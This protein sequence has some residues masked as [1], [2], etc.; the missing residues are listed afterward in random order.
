MPFSDLMTGA[1]LTPSFQ[2]MIR[3]LPL[4]LKEDITTFSTI[5]QLWVREPLHEG[6]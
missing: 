1:D 6:H 2:W 4:I 3:Y 5:H